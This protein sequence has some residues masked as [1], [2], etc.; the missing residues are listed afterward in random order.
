MSVHRTNTR[1]KRAHSNWFDPKQ[2]QIQNDNLVSDYWKMCTVRFSVDSSIGIVV[3]VVV[4]SIV[5]I[6]FHVP[7]A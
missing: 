5:V 2:W 4:P 6:L 7:I 1:A 3:D